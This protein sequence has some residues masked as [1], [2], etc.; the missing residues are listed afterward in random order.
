MVI[1]GEKKG[2]ESVYYVEVDGEGR[3][4]KIRSKA[5]DTGKERIVFMED[6]E[7]RRVQV[8]VSKDRN[9]LFIRSESPKESEVWVVKSQIEESEDLLDVFTPK[10]LISRE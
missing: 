10:L 3:P 6:D 4:F 7:S 8:E 2:K 9:V 1:F 5:V